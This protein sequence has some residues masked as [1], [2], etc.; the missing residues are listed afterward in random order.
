MSTTAFILIEPGVGT[1][2]SAY[3]SLINMKDVV[4]V[5]LVTGPYDLIAV[6]SSSDLNAVGDLVTNQIHT[7]SGIV[8]TVTCLGIKE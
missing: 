8:R 3:E 1:T 5:D 2:Q 4:S 6:I 7:I